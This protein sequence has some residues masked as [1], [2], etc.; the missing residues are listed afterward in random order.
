M[1]FDQY[2]QACGGSM[3]P[4]PEMSRSVFWCIDCGFRLESAGLIDVHNLLEESSRDTDADLGEDPIPK[5][6]SNSERKH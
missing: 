6:P 4:I 1:I 5:I 2:C 3:V